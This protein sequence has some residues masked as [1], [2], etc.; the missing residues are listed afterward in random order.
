MSFES[1]DGGTTWELNMPF[2]ECSRRDWSGTL[3]AGG[4]CSHSIATW[5]GDP[6]RLALGISAVG[7]WLSDDAG[8]TWRHGNDGLVARYVPEESREGTC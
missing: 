7:V 1:R 5:P 8:K 4:M 6:S 3:G 2:W